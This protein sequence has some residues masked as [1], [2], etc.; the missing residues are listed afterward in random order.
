M[1]PGSHVAAAGAATWLRAPFRRP[2]R[3]RRVRFLRGATPME[4]GPSAVSVAERARETPVDYETVAEF[5]N[6]LGYPTRLE[7]LDA[8]R[9]P[10]TLSEIKLA[11]R[12][13]QPGDN[14]ERAAARQTVQAHLDKLVDADL[15]HVDEVEL[16]GRP[17]NRYVVNP[18]KLYALIEELR[19]LSVMYAG[20]GPAGD[21]TG[22]LSGGPSAQ[23]VE[24]PRLTLVHG[25]YEGKSFPLAPDEGERWVI[26]RR[27][28]LAVSLD[29][30]PFVSLENA[31][32]A[33]KRGVF[34][35]TDIAGS[36]NGTSV[37]WGVLPPGGSRKLKAGDIIGVGRSLLC[38]VPE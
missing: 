37:N 11:P 21:A 32:I 18:T 33:G 8:L 2:R 25:V 6:A 22:T 5:M 27:R 16:G 34:T 28:G 31:A 4:S 36:K 38:F 9:F 7:L 26:G 23:T 17:V 3:F 1:Y 29:Y 14:P 12:R 15:V 20:R 35:I 10:H 30:D 13:L 19:R 24:G